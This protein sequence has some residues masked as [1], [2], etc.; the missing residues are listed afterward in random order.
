MF[1][2]RIVVFSLNFY[3]FSIEKCRRCILY[4]LPCKSRIVSVQPSIIIHCRGVIAMLTRIVVVI[5]MKS[6]VVG[7]SAL[8]SQKLVPLSQTMTVIIWRVEPSVTSIHYGP[9]IHVYTSISVSTC[10]AT[11]ECEWDLQRFRQWVTFRL[12]HIWKWLITRMYLN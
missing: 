9:C 12:F 10:T 3:Y 11:G 7:K 4:H 2:L 1:C 8:A 6:D 5:Y